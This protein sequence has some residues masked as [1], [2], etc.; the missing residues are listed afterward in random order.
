MVAGVSVC[1]WY[2]CACAG[3]VC[4]YVRVMCAGGVCVGG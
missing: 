3:G 1:R 4:V 2:V